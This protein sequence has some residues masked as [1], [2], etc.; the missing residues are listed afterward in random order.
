MD[1]ECLLSPAQSATEVQLPELAPLLTSTSPA[2][3]LPTSFVSPNLV[4][5]P[6]TAFVHESEPVSTSLLDLDQSPQAL[7]LCPDHFVRLSCRLQIHRQNLSA[8]RLRLA[9]LSLHCCLLPISS[10]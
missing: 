7:T 10:C 3:P 5:F 1:L 8:S 4:N 9:S 6:E 2:L